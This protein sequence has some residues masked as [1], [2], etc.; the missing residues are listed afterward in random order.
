VSQER[1]R[2][3]I[4]LPTGALSITTNKRRRK[5]RVT[6]TNA[7]D[8]T[9]NELEQFIAN[10]TFV[11]SKNSQRREML[12]VSIEQSELLNG[13]L[14]KL[15]SI[16]ARRT[17]PRSSLIFELA[18]GGRI[19]DFRELLMEGK[20]SVWDHDEEGRSLLFVS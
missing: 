18:M 4:Q 8:E 11:P 14:L 15:P 7:E 16:I 5:N 3:N 13:L 1:K 6:D 2:K 9:D 12:S 20:A 10:V 19:D 17:I